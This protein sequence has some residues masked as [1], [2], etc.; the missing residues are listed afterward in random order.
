MFTI[1]KAAGLRRV[2][3]Y[4]YTYRINAKGRWF[5]R[6]L[7][8]VFTEE[9]KDQPREYYA[10]MGD[11]EGSIDMSDEAIR[12]V[13]EDKDLVV[14]DK[15]ASIPVH[16]TGRYNH[17]TITGILK[18]KEFGYKDVFPVNR[19]DRLTSGILLLALNKEKASQLSKSFTDRA[20]QKTYLC[21]VR[22]DFP[23]GAVTCS[24]PIKVVTNSQGINTV[25]P[26]GLPSETEFSKISFD[27]KTS[28]VNQKLD[29]C[30]RYASICSF[31]DFLLQTIPFMRM[32]RTG[33]S[34]IFHHHTISKSDRLSTRGKELAKGGGAD[35]S[36]VSK[37]IKSIKF[38]R[39]LGEDKVESSD[40]RNHE[41]RFK[42]DHDS[43]SSNPETLQSRSH[44]NV[45]S[46][47]ANAVDKD[48]EDP[49]PCPWCISPIP[50][51][52]E[53][54]M[55]IFLHAWKYNGDGWA[56]ETEKPEWAK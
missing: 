51:P 30:I 16:P 47:E 39:M 19:L 3:P 9:F 1:D 4:N 13:Y 5:S 23:D 42:S 21:R 8:D 29:E 49:F 56:Y 15:P 10:I 26:D 32:K 31:L 14:V 24:E 44:Q 38:K 54:E 11:Y 25:S 12:I 33:V 43:A 35:A 17:N 36:E 18:S 52:P 50:D 7:V 55:S 20:M 34:K 40:G 45:N 6:S 2:L 22:G 46:N 41:K 37:R 27:G 53:H 48:N 28:L